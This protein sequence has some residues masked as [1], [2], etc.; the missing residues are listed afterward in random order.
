VIDRWNEQ[1]NPLTSKREC[2]ALE[3]VG[4]FMPEVIEQEQELK[5]QALTVVEK[6]Q[7]IVIKDRQSYDQASQL[8][9]EQIIPFRKKWAEY[10]EPLKKAAFAA[11]RA[12]VAKYD[13]GDAPA[14]KAEAIVKGAIRGWDLEQQRIQDEL[15]RK[16]QEA[17]EAAEREERLNAA[18][19]AEQAG[20]SE[21]DVDRIVSAPVSV[22]A[23]PVAPVYQKAPGV[24]VRESWKCVVVDIKK[25]C[26]A[27]AKG[28]IS[29]EYVLPNQT[30]LNAR[31]RADKKT[32]NIPGCVAR[33]E[34][35]VAGRA[36]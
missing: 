18:V 7:A 9:L 2:A 30:A 16:A 8:L 13:E 31:A 6:A 14:A 35:I 4:N 19:V 36:K 1:A 20:A 21:E 12:I 10:W 34:G 33:N 28:A 29:A 22:V 24:S 23:A 3:K 25:L 27:V 17:A 32:L 5:Q 11:H 26:L 15:Q